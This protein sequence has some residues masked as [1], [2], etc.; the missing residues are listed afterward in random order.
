MRGDCDR[1]LI[2]HPHLAEDVANLVRPAALNGAPRIGDRQRGEQTRAA[3]DANHLE[4]GADEATADQ[5]AKE[6]LPFGR[7]LALT[8]D[9]SR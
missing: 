3:I 7:A 5:I 8:P 9:G 6:A 4:A 2:G 1:R